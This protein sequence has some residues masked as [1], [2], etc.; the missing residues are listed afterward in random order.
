MHVRQ[1]TVAHGCLS[2]LRCSSSLTEVASELL[3]L[4]RSLL[5]Q[6]ELTEEAV[7]DSLVL[8]SLEL[9]DGQP[10]SKRAALLEEA[11]EADVAGLEQG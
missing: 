6:N 7:P 3:Q 2:S 1:R 5:A 11:L 8:P 10:P 4:Q 9:D